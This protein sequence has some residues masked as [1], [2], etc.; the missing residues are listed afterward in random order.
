[1]KNRVESLDRLRGIMC[2]L[3]TFFTHCEIFNPIWGYISRCVEIFITISGLGMA[4]AYKKKS[5]A[6]FCS[7]Y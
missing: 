3:I 6:I 2:L 4:Y 7:S 1:M 5:Y